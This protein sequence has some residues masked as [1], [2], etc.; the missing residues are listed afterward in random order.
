MATTGLEAF[1]TTIHKSNVWLNDVMTEL[2]VRDR[3]LAY[4][5]LRAAL[6]A[7]R[8]RLPLEIVVHFAAQLPM[9]IRGL[10]FE[11]WHPGRK[12]SRMHLVDFLDSIDAHLNVIGT[13]PESDVIA[14]AVF[15]TVSKHVT[16]GLVVD[17][18]RALPEELRALWPRDGADAR[19]SASARGLVRPV[20]RVYARRTT[21]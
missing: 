18:E 21:R 16:H 13:L 19:I 12:P 6:H 3:H 14:G 10:F 9:L 5:A 4:A 15:M 17:I 11:G 2:G 8:D 7:L 20:A 1:D